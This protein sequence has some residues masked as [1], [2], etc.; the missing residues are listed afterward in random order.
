MGTPPKAG[1]GSPSLKS[2]F[3]GVDDSK[4]LAALEAPYT[5]GRPPYPAR[6]LLRAFLAKHLLNISYNVDL[7]QRLRSGHELRDACGF[8]HHTPS[9]PTLSRFFSRLVPHEALVERCISTATGR[10]RRY[11]PNLGETMAID[12]TD[13]EAWA[14]P[15]RHADPDARWGVRHVIRSA[16]GEE[17]EYYF[18]YKAHTLVCADSGVPLG[19]ILTTA[20]TN[21]APMFTPLADKAMKS[22]PWLKPSFIVADRG[23]DSERNHRA[24]VSRGITPIIH[25]R[26]NPKGS[27]VIYDPVAGAPTCL[28]KQAMRYIRTDPET[29]HHL[30]RCPGQGCQLKTEGSKAI[31]HCD[32]EVWENP[33]DN[34]R[35]VGIVARQSREWWAL[36]NKR[37][38]VERLFRSAK[39]SRLLDT[40]QQRCLERVRLHTALSLLA[41]SLTALAWLKAKG[42]VETRTAGRADFRQ[43]RIAKVA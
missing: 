36:Y 29:G 1:G 22:L 21:D 32:D 25:I 15:R 4:L 9:A 42:K 26:S 24:A 14:H 37:Q 3:D 35:V 7:V 28:G 16:G 30:F 33:A 41:Y 17:M 8:G 34:L 40:H 23:Y 38:S 20:N 5:T 18:G 11:L 27:S 12:S 10:M 6:A 39:H 2:I 31:R 19:F 13:I 43:M